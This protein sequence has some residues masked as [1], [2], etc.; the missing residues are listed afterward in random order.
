MQVFPKTIVGPIKVTTLITYIIQPIIFKGEKKI[1]FS[2][3][4]AMLTKQMFLNLK[5]RAEMRRNKPTKIMKC[6]MTK[7]GKSC[8]LWRNRP[9][10]KSQW[11]RKMTCFH[12]FTVHY[13]KENKA[14]GHSFPDKQILINFPGKQSL[15]ALFSQRLF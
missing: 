1:T 2:S 3:W 10:Q 12:L 11:I 15:T 14:L 9:M 8:V 5:R 13:F 7:R 6:S 4:Q